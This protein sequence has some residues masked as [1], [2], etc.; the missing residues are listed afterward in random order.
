MTDTAKLR[1]L[2]LA[3]V[4]DVGL[5]PVG[6][7][8]HR[9]EPAADSRQCGVTGVVL[10]AESHVAVHTWPEIGGVTIDAYVCNFSADNSLRARRLLEYLVAAF[11][12]QRVAR[13][14]LQRSSP[15]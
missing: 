7:L 12:P 6:E 15:A 14:Q 4:V 3:A 8:F 5:T 11:A 1:T 13:Q 2:C 9:F 10:L